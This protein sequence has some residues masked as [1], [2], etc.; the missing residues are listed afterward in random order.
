MDEKQNEVGPDN[1]EQI[2]EKALEKKIKEEKITNLERGREVISKAVKKFPIHPGIYKMIG[3][4][5][6]VLYVGKAK[7]L[8]NRVTSYTNVNELNYRIKQMVSRVYEV[9][10]NV[11]DTDSDAIFLEADLIRTIKPPYNVKLKDATPFV[12]ISISKTI[13]PRI[14]KHRGMRDYKNYDFCGPFSSVKSVNEALVNIQKIFQLRTCPDKYFEK[15]T[16]P[17][18]QYDIKRCSAPCVNKINKEEYLLS[19]Q[20]AKD[21][22][23]GKLTNVKNFLKD[24]MMV[25]SNEMNFEKAARYRDSI[26]RL[27]KLSYI[28]KNSTKGLIDADIIAISKQRK[29]DVEQET[30]EEFCESAP[31]IQVLFVRNEMYLG[32]DT[33]FL[34]KEAIH[35]PEE[36]NISTFLKQLYLNTEPPQK[37]LLSCL[38]CDA[39]EIV[40]A[41]KSRY[42]KKVVIEVPKKGVG[43]MW[44]EQALNN[45]NQ[46][47]K[48]EIAKNMDFSDNFEKLAKIFALSKVPDRIEIYDNSHIQ[49]KYA[50]G[51]MVVA[52]KE[53]FD[54]KSYRKFSFDKKINEGNIDGEAIEEAEEI[55]KTEEGAEEQETKNGGDDYWMMQEMFKRRFKEEGRNLLPDLIFVDGGAGQVSSALKILNEYELYIPII[56][57]AKG[58]HRNAGRE[59]FFIPGFNPFTLAEHEP[60]LHFIQRLR[61]ESH[62]FAIGTHRS[63]RDK[64]FTK[65]QLSEIQGIGG[66]RKKMLLKTFGSVKKIRQASIE[67]L[68][69]VP[70]IT[71]GIAK[72]IYDFFH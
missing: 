31:C 46:Q 49:G 56:G 12:S 62:R 20:N 9:L 33:F 2:S 38:P 59:R 1:T 37:I 44:I 66:V 17:C 61:D 11:T 58:V 48:Y 53:G 39:D 72:T 24:E 68:M 25:A 13:Y 26:R 40:D 18:L 55:E 8:K 41:I 45:A 21:F 19:V 70:T 27:E 35:S 3:E 23:T 54:K 6:E 57:I 34:T 15:R 60:I 14:E 71:K 36:V 64:N 69:K 30:D 22:L 10:F 43:L 7:N 42:D 50:Y 4:N 51:C 16:R 28:E 29:L 32:G 47:V 63:S 65:S 5:G 67:D 52:N